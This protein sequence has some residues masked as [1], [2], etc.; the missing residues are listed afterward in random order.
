MVRRLGTSA[1]CA[2]LLGQAVAGCATMSEEQQGAAMGATVGA[3]AGGLGAGLDKHNRAR[4]AMI[5]VTTGALLGAAAGWGVGHYRA[6][7]IRDREEAARATGYKPAQGVFAM[8]ED[9]LA[10]PQPAQP[11]DHLI[12]RAR[13]TVLAPAD[14]PQITVR[15]S[16]AIY[17]NDQLLKEMPVKERTRSQGTDQVQFDLTVPR[18]VA[19]G[20]YSIVI[21]VEPLAPN[22]SKARVR[23]EFM[24]RA[25]APAAQTALVE[26]AA[27]PTVRPASLTETVPAAARPMVAEPVVATLAP[28]AAPEMLQVKIESANIREGASPRFRMITRAPRGA[29]LTVLEAAGPTAD[30]WYHVR[31]PNGAEGWVAG[32]AVTPSR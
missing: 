17:F 15:E 32:S 4:G 29:M 24:V 6:Q 11:G 30:R 31:L 2:V 9:P 25:P 12:F 3:L 7:Q 22:A 14:G 23:S 8:V 13:Y 27:T 20:T 16:A 19:D 18:D 28:V 26:P 1:L 5:G 21:V 10:L